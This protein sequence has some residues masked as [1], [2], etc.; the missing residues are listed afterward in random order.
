MPFRE[1]DIVLLVDLQAVN[2][3]PYGAA[4]I[5]DSAL[6]GKTVGQMASIIASCSSIGCRPGK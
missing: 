4:V 5:L 2:G 3:N 6:T 1:Q